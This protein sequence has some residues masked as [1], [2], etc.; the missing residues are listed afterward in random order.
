MGKWKID[1]G[2]RNGKG[3]INHANIF[4]LEP[5]FCHFN[6]PHFCSNSQTSFPRE[7][8]PLSRNAQESTRS[9]LRFNSSVHISRSPEFRSD[10]T[11][12]SLSL[13]LSLHLP[14]KFILMK[15]IKD[16][17]RTQWHYDYCL[18]TAHRVSLGCIYRTVE[19]LPTKYRNVLQ[20][21]ET[22]F[23]FPVLSRPMPKEK[24]KSA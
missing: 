23:I 24:D 15:C 11:F 7:F 13:F 2:T 8:S 22:F 21:S 5:N 16:G 17:K 20:I 14:A 19:P 9:R 3:D 1:F 12:A 4:P 6:L 10:E 18:A